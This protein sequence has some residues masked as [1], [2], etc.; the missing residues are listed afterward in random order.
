MKTN[1]IENLIWIFICGIG[2]IFLIIGIVISVNLFNY[3]NTVETTGV[4]TEIASYRDSDGDKN[5]DVYVSYEVNGQQYES[6]M[7]SYSSSFYEGKEIEIY[8]DKDN[9]NK[10]GM[11]SLDFIFLIFP[12]IGLLFFSIGGIALLIKANKKKMEKNLKV[13]GER[14]EANYVET[15]LNTSYSV[16]GRNPYYIVCEWNNPEDEK[17]YIFK[18]GN[19]WTNPE[20]IIK[21]KDI[22]TFP[23]YLDKINKKK[24]VVDIDAITDKVVDLT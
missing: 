12:G 5:Y 2:L 8:Y 17:L 16:N 1:K 15:L 13:Y 9:P 21:E 23:V 18:S 11:K 4:I 20:K 14:I 6:E 22:K 3:E 24:Y 7:N 10:I 19:I